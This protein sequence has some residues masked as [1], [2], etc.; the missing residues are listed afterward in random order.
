MHIFKNKVQAKENML[1]GWIWSTDFKVELQ[2]GR[3]VVVRVVG[4][5]GLWNPG[6][7]FRSQ[8]DIFLS[9]VDHQPITYLFKPLCAVTKWQ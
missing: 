5:H 4:A 9:C 8:F 7:R 3:G 6:F 2:G 1:A